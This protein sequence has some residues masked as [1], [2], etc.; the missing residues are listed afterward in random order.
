MTSVFC[1]RFHQKMKKSRNGLRNYPFQEKGS[2]MDSE[3]STCC[4]FLLRQLFLV[5]KTAHTRGAV[6]ELLDLVIV[7]HSPRF[8]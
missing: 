8:A 3:M 7:R 1:F 4:C 5:Q 2:E 6:R